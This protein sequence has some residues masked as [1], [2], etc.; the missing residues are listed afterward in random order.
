[1]AHYTGQV[2]DMENDWGGG[3]LHGVII[4]GQTVKQVAGQT[5]AY[6]GEAV[7]LFDP[8]TGLVLEAVDE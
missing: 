2:I 3:S 5:V 1:M 7:D 4:H 6:S 8:S